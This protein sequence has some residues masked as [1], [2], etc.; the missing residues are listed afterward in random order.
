MGSHYYAYSVVRQP[1]EC[2]PC[3]HR[4]GFKKFWRIKTADRTRVE[5]TE[6][7]YER[8]RKA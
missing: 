4:T 5:V 7:E 3:E 8:E 6:E 1:C 2:R